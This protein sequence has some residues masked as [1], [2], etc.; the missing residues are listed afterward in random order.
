MRAYGLTRADF[1]KRFGTRNPQAKDYYD[2]LSAARGF[3]LVSRVDEMQPGDIIAIEYPPGSR[4]TGHVMI[5]DSRPAPRAAT[6]PV[7]PQTRQYEVAVIDSSASFHGFDDTRYVRGAAHGTGVG[8]GLFRL[9]ADAAGRVTGYSWS[10]RSVS[11]Y[12]QFVQRPLAVGHFD[13]G[14]FQAAPTHEGEPSEADDA[15]NQ[16]LF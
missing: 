11:H 7:E 1:E 15:P 10:V 4:P 8:R 2:A 6:K 14:P 5:V 16:G 9:Y 12:Y 3:S 13:T